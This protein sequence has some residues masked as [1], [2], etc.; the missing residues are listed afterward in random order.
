MARHAGLLRQL[1][2]HLAHAGNY[3]RAVQCRPA[4]AA[5]H[6]SLPPPVET[7]E[8]ALAG[9]EGRQDPQSIAERFG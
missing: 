4:S 2:E 9:L 3:I 8:R 1:N 6:G 5:R 7:L